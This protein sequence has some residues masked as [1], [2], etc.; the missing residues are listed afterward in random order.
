MSVMHANNEIGVIQPVREIGAI[1][2]EM[3]VLFHCDAAQAFGKVPIDVT[4]D[5]IDLLSVSAHKLYGPKGVGALYVRR[6]VQLA[7]QMD[8]GGHESG[9]RSGTLNVPAI[10]GFGEACA[11]CGA[12]W[13]RR[14][15]ARLT[16]RER[17]L[18]RLQCGLDGVIGERLDGSPA[19][20]K[21]KSQLRGVNADTLLMSLPN[22]AVSTGS[23]CS[24]A[25]AE[26]SHVLRAL[27]L[28][29][30]GEIVGAIRGRT[31]QYGRRDRLG[32]AADCGVG[33]EAAVV[34]AGV[35]TVA[36]A[37]LQRFVQ[38]G[39]GLAGAYPGVHDD[40]IFAN[41]EISGFAG[42]A[43]EL[44]DRSFER[45]ANLRPGQVKLVEI[46]AELVG[47]RVAGD[48]EE[49]H[50]LA[51]EAAI[52]LDHAGGLFAAG[53]A[54]RRPKFDEQEA[55]A[56]VGELTRLTIDVGCGEIRRRGVDP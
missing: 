36:A 41:E 13:R 12:R 42:D 50:F 37:L 3:G 21:S 45:L 51:G 26:P 23:A 18:T 44:V 55:A 27:G 35:V 14:R 24:S 9:R 40:A 20:R 43:I 25:V 22:V 1:C 53:T 10:V 7:A 33:H 48:T 19:A 29:G 32:R 47:G 16:L 56:V 4:A 8:G 46:A 38:A 5:A 39:G 52:E 28:G 11:W 2:R 6:N 30:C 34:H 17:L 49:L 31:V 15:I 54:Q